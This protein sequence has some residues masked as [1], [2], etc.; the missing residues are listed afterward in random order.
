MYHLQKRY[1]VLTK[2]KILN[3]IIQRVNDTNRDRKHFSSSETTEILSVTSNFENVCRHEKILHE[4]VHTH[5]D[6]HTNSLT[7]IH[8]HT[9]TQTH[10]QKECHMCQQLRALQL[11]FTLS[12]STIRNNSY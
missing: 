12:P 2:A 3:S 9:H 4:T 1:T 8:V 5:T 6:T 11:E 7:H 10:T